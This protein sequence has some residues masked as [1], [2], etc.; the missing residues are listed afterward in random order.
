MQ[1]NSITSKIPDSTTPITEHR[2]MD[3]NVAKRLS[4]RVVGAP[5]YKGSFLLSFISSFSCDSS[6][7]SS[8]DSED[9]SEEVNAEYFPNFSR[10]SDQYC[11]LYLTKI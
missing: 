4:A 9:S 10:C 7:S 6:D 5:T 1:C 3:V 11:L 2:A 8:D